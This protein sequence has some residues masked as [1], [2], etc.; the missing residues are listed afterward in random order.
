[1]PA[2]MKLCTLRSLVS[3]L[4]LCAVTRGGP[5]NKPG[6]LVADS[7][8]GTLLDSTISSDST[9]VEFAF[10][11]RLQKWPLSPDGFRAMPASRDA[12]KRARD[13][14]I[15]QQERQV[16][17]AITHEKA[18]R[19]PSAQILLKSIARTE[20]TA[21][22]MQNEGW[23]GSFP[24]RNVPCGAPSSV[25][26]SE[27]SSSWTP[28]KSSSSSFLST[29]LS[30]TTPP[31]CGFPASDHAKDT[32]ESSPV[33][34]VH[35]GREL[36]ATKLWGEI[37][38]L[39]ALRSGERCDDTGLLPE[40]EVEMETFQLLEQACDFIEAKLPIWKNTG[41]KSAGLSDERRVLADAIEAKVRN[42]ND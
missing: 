32:A 18:K 15:E 26:S 20:I 27:S 4:T 19:D 7:S 3:S 34:G 37:H 42:L 31:P 24:Q 13:E 9:Q 25:P 22:T 11:C 12:L 41:A 2:K 39:V 1:M 14:D 40:E 28:S 29:Q 33:A 30:S 16:R 17:A 35:D 36:A 6:R 38:L 10:A 5:V 8:S 21:Q 23:F